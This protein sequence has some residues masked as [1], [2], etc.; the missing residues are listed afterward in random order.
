MAVA[1]LEIYKILPGTNC[2]DCGHPTCLSFVNDLV[3]RGKKP[4]FCP[5][6]SAADRRKINDLVRAGSPRKLESYGQV[7]FHPLETAIK[8]VQPLNLSYL[9]ALMNEGSVYH[10][11]DNS[12]TLP[13]LNTKLTVTKEQIV[14]K[15]G[16]PLPPGFQTAVYNYLAIVEKIH[17]ENQWV[18]FKELPGA[19]FL[20]SYFVNN[21]EGLVSAQFASR[22]NQLISAAGS[23]SGKILDNPE[24]SPAD[25][26]ISFPL[27]PKIAIRL[28]FWDGTEED[29]L[30][31]V[32]TFLFDTGIYR[33]DLESLTYLIEELVK[34]MIA[35]I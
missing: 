2:G 8:R 22:A 17:P 29:N 21:V 30:P 13:F 11:E 14:D 35:T 26:K 20:S 4:E 24:I 12:I 31:A 7:M 9:S 25:V 28:L 19:V 3:F 33:L 16:V 5:H 1:S 18:S 34:R 6:L 10:A 27:V 32:A 15:E 23:L